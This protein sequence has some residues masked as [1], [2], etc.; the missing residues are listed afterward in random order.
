[1]VW[2][3]GTYDILEGN[4]WKGKLHIGMA[5]KKLQGEFLLSKD[6][7]KGGAWVLE[8]VGD[9]ANPIAASENDASALSARS[10]TEIAQASDRQWKSNRWAPTK[11]SGTKPRASILGGR[12]ARRASQ[13]ARGIRRT[14]A[15]QAGT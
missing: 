3:I 15:V 12:A 5:G 7:R 4:Y 1:M 10:M 14:H 6:T 2:N 9:A 13:S 11:D 8:K